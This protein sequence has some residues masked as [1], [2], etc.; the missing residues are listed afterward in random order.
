MKSKQIS[1]IVPIYNIPID[2][3]KECL[4][5]L[6][7]QT[8]KDEIEIILIDDGSIEECAKVCDEYA[9]MYTD[10]KVIHQKNQGVSMARNAGI[11]IAIGKW[12]MFVDP[13]DWVEKNICEELLKYAKDDIDIIISSCNECYKNKKIKISTFDEDYIEFNENKI[14]ILQLQLI[15]NEALEKKYKKAEYIGTPWSKLYRASFI[16]DNNL[17]FE[18]GVNR[19]QDVIFNLY[20][21]EMARKIL[22]KKSFLYNYRKCSASVTNKHDKIIIDYYL[23]YMKE[24]LRFIKKFDKTNI[25]YE[26]YYIRTLKFL[27]EIINKYVFGKNI[28][29][30]KNGKEEL[31][32]ILALEDINNA[33]Y[34]I[35]NR[36]LSLY[37]KSLLGA[38]KKQNYF[39][40]SLITCVRYIIKKIYGQDEKNMY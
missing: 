16:R 2:Y 35:N 24:E 36:N 1:V 6:V 29:N 34:K 21:F 30:Y 5:S 39:I 3:F 33:L 20:S 18:K 7:N 37:Q 22:Y 23:K 13:D 26:A 40:I 10:I 19:G 25:F 17:R 11:E 15:A 27:S 28:L 8:I 31:K 38:L 32:N 4:N 12:I 14:E 9:M